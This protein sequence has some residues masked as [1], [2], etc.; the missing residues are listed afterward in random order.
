MDVTR[1]KRVERDWAAVL[2]ECDGSGLS[3]KEFC[4]REGMSQSLFYRRHKE[5][6]AVGVAGKRSG[7]RSDFIELTGGASS[8]FSARMVF[9]GGIELSISNDCKPELLGQILSQLRG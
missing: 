9:G 1:K 7:R 8:R 6:G 5:V 3:I 4:R 2:V